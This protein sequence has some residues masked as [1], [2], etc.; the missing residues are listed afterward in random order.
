MDK[1]LQSSQY[2]NWQHPL[3][4]QQADKFKA[5]AKDRFE[6]VKDCFEWVRDKISHSNDA[7]DN[8][9]TCRASDVLQQGT[10]YCYAKSH[11]LAALLRANEIPAGLCYQR[12][13]RDDTGAPFCLHG[14][15]AVYLAEYGWYRVDPRGNKPGVDAQFSPPL[16]QLAFAIASPGEADLREIWSDPL[17]VVVDVLQRFTSYQEVWRNLPDVSL[18]PE[19]LGSTK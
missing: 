3:V 2:I 18:L 16:E 4:L 9:I 5:E 15:N 17:P 1:Y 6:L 12:L 7:Q 13:S 8:R 10:G 14:L 19:L 11:L